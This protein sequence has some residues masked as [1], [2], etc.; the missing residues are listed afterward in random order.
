MLWV[1][2]AVVL[3][4]ASGILYAALGPLRGTAS[5]RTLQVFALLQYALAGVL[6]AAR[7]TGYA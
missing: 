3:L 5:A 2:I 6:I 1:L 4:S 7:V